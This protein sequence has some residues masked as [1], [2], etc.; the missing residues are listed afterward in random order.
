MSGGNQQQD[1]LA[2]LEKLAESYRGIKFGRGVVGKTSYATLA[3]VAVWLTIIMRL[4]ANLWLDVALFLAGGAATAVYVWW[5]SRTQRFATENPG[6]ALLEGAELIE[7]QK[8]EAQI[9][10]QPPLD[11]PRIPDPDAERLEDQ[12]DQ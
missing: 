8:W 5:V 9:K 11:S 4:S 2:T 10:G 1:P 7:Y 12:R 6:L 3:I